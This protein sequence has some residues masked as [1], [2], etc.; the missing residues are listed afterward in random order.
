MSKVRVSG[1]A[2]S[3]SRGAPPDGVTHR[4]VTIVGG[5]M[6]GI[7]CMHAL[8]RLSD[9]AVV[10]LVEASPELGGRVCTRSVIGGLAFDYGASYFSCKPGDPS[11]DA[12]PFAEAMRAAEDARV[13]RPWDGRGRIGTAAC[14]KR[15]DG[16]YAIDPS[17]FESF[18]SSKRILVGVP[19]MSSVPR[20][21]ARNLAGAT[22]PDA[23]DLGDAAAPGAPEYLT[24]TFVEDVVPLPEVVGA[25]GSRR[26]SHRMTLRVRDG[27]HV[28]YK[29]WETD[30]VILATNAPA[31]VRLLTSGGDDSSF[32]V[33]PRIAAAAAGVKANACWTLMVAFETPLNLPWDGV[34]MGEPFESGVAW[35]ANNSSKPGRDDDGSGLSSDGGGSRTGDEMSWGYAAAEAEAATG[36]RECWVVQ[37]SPDWSN[38]RADASAAEVASELLAAFLALVVGGDDGNGNGNG[39]A[40]AGGACAYRKAF[41]WK[42]AYPLNPVAQSQRPTGWF[43]AA[44]GVGACGDWTSGA[45]ASDAYDSGVE[46]G[47]VV[48]EHLRDL[49]T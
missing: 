48:A 3:V 34:M 12:S 44:A 4:R 19:R 1:R 8:S 11:F 9:R 36:E 16:S 45:R 23:V 31:A 42:H 24:S 32:D 5:G 35:F 25:D 14:V 21:I 46:L 43:D 17:S 30:L 2:E 18:P 33:A 47:R 29:P 27:G 15:G 40:D 49:A 6:A 20:F 41:K 39:A 7:G 22:R 10:T 28:W 13:V 37:A 38:A 26:R